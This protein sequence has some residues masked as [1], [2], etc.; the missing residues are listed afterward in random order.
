MSMRGKCGTES[1]QSLCQMLNLAI[2][3]DQIFDDFDTFCAQIA[4]KTA[5]AEARWLIYLIS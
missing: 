2:A 4:E 3:G 5:R 1:S